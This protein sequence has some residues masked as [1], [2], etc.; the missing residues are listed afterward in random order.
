MAF[1]PT[2]IRRDDFGF[3][4]PDSVTWKVWTYPTALIGFQR[5]VTLEHF[6]PFLTA[7]V[8]DSAGIYNDP[9]TRFDHTLTYFLLV[10]I[11]DGRT[12]IQVSEHLMQI[13]AKMTGIE[14]ISGRRYSANNPDSQLWIHIT[15][16]HSVL[17]AYEVFGP[18]PLTTEEEEQF[19]AEC[20]I[21]AELQTCKVEDVPRNRAEVRAYFERMRPTLAVSER[22]V[23]GMHHLLWTPRAN[24][25]GWALYL[26][27][28]V[29]SLTSSAIT[30]RWMRKLGRYDLP[31]FLYVANVLPAKLLVRLGVMN[32]LFGLR[33]VARALVPMTSAVLEQHVAA[34]APATLETITPAEARARYSTRGTDAP[35]RVTG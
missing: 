5:A 22:A 30:P 7:S 9:R 18:G 10:A 1:D 12:A 26:G 35:A 6:D 4:G 29:L 34:A 32:E 16:W 33:V 31:T 19:W 21:A 27:S 24:G 17:K 20:A 23:E 2:T 14:P 15:G 25:A 3:F 28:R 13:H 11:G 8:A